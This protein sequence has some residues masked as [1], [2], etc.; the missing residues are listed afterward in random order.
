MHV[1]V[2]AAVPLTRTELNKRAYDEYPVYPGHRC[3]TSPVVVQYTSKKTKQQT[4]KVL[5][6]TGDLLEAFL[7]ISFVVLQGY[8]AASSRWGTHASQP[9]RRRRDEGVVCT[10]SLL[11][12]HHR[13]HAEQEHGGCLS[14]G[15]GNVDG[16]R[17]SAL[18]RRRST[19]AGSAARGP[20]DGC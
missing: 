17:E 2:P 19:G 3:L 1:C 5:L 8:D 20:L 11:S 4:L 9:D 14:A 10:R 15:H 6:K 18:R 7:E 13:A 12:H 16:Q